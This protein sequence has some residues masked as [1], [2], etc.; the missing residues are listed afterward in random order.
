[1]GGEM[2]SLYLALGDSITAGYG[3]GLKSCF[4]SLLSARLRQHNPGLIYR[5]CGVNGLTTGRLNAVLNSAPLAVSLPQATLISITIGSNDFLH[6]IPLLTSGPKHLQK[7]LTRLMDANLDAMGR[8]IRHLNP[9]ATM[10]IAG[11]YNPLPLTAF[12]AYSPLAERLIDSFNGGLCRWAQRYR[13]EFI[14][15]NHIFKGREAYV[16]GPDRL[17]PNQYGHLLIAQSFWESGRLSSVAY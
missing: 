12:V 8:Q 7:N 5:N 2:M 4:A 16:L 1:M 9:Q 6:A 10:Q 11:L 13:A 3:V 14:P 17:H 15:L